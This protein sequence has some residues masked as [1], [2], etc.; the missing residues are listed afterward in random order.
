MK[1]ARGDLRTLPPCGGGQ[2]QGVAQAFADFGLQGRTIGKVGPDP[3]PYPSPTRGEGTPPSL[4][5]PSRRPAYST[6][7]AKAR[8]RRN[9]GRAENERR[10]E[11]ASGAAFRRRR[12]AHVV[13]TRRGARR[14]DGPRNAAVERL[15]RRRGPPDGDRTFSEP[16]LLVLSAR[17]SQ[18][19]G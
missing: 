13:E 4:R 5:S 11:G 12:N 9:N 16:G 19:G 18:C 17:R 3:P 6:A 7:D 2:G 15:R 8:L 1:E 10:P 14:A